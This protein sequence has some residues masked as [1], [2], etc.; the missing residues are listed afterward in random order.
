[1][2]VKD[3]WLLDLINFG[4]MGIIAELF[5]NGYYK[6]IETFKLHNNNT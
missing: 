3:T 4:E 1:M 2:D 6:P 5:I